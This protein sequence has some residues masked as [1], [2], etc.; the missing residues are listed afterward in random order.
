MNDLIPAPKAPPADPLLPSASVNMTARRRPPAQ[1][2]R[3]LLFVLFWHRGKVTAFF[4]VALAFTALA[5]VVMPSTYKSD[6]TLLVKLGADTVNPDISAQI[7]GQVIQP[8]IQRDTQM[9]TELE[10]LKS[11]EIAISVVKKLGP[12]HILRKNAQPLSGDVSDPMFRQ[13]LLAL[14]QNLSLDVVPDTGVLSVSYQSGDSRLAQQIV[15]TYV[16][17]YLAQRGDVYTNSRSAKYLN[18]Q[19]EE[20]IGKME[21][22]QTQ[23]RQIKASAGIGNPEEQRQILQARI[24]GL[25]HDA[26]EA[27]TNRASAEASI[28]AITGQL[29]IVPKT[30]DTQHTHNAAMNWVDESKKENAKLHQD[31]ADA[32]VRYQPTSIQVKVLEERVAASDAQ[33]AKAGDQGETIEG[34][35]PAYQELSTRLETSRVESRVSEKKEAALNAELATAKVELDKLNNT[36]QQIAELQRQYNLA[37]D[38]LKVVAQA[39][40]RAS[41]LQGFEDHGLSNITVIQPATLPLK[42]VAPNRLLILV[43]GMFVAGSGAVALAIGA[44]AMSRSTKRPEDIDRLTALPSVSV[45]VVDQSAYLGA[46]APAVGPA[47]VFKRLG[48]AKETGLSIVTRAAGTNGSRNGAH[49]AA[50]VNGH[51]TVTPVRRWSPQL[52]Q[53]AHGIIDGLL[54]DSILS[55]KGS[56]TFVTGLVSCRP[57]QGASTLSSYIASAIADRLE[58]SSVMLDDEQVLLIDADLTEPTQHRL[59][60]MNESPGLGDWLAVASDADMSLD[61]FIQHTNHGRLSLMAAGRTTGVTRL[62]DRADRLLEQATLSHRHV[63]IDLPPVS[64]TPTSLRLAAKCNAVLVVVECGNLHQEVVRRTVAALQQAGANVAGVVLNKRRFP[65]PD[66]LYERSS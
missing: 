7:G 48:L 8:V 66:W 61:P 41:I 4:L 36:A 57:G 25:E 43:L 45:P 1:S 46:P 27:R 3:D 11:N 26:A 58:G 10:V 35:N 6:S 16:N 15:S 22:L 34:V 62:L 64:S 12:G 42:P 38:K 59:L 55:A 17:S 30:I 39:A 40:D 24:G 52:L 21:D 56:A 50:H 37:E 20:I 31:L 44:E 53:A 13:A 2:P 19:R 60:S 23:M 29:A 32:M 54:F 14:Q 65:I 28:A 9:K 63:V 49:T 5:V 33:L 18:G 51:S 47:G